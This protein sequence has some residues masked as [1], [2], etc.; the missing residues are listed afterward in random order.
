MDDFVPPAYG[1]PVGPKRDREDLIR[2]FLAGSTSG[3]STDLRAEGTMLITTQGAVAALRLAADVVL[4]RGHGLL[5]EEGADIRA[6]LQAQGFHVVQE[7]PVLAD[8]VALMMCGL[9]GTAWNLWGKAD[10]SAVS[11]LEQ[12]ATGDVAVELSA[13]EA[14]LA[15]D[16]AIVD[17]EAQFGG[18][19]DP[20]PAICS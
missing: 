19:T 5:Q 16:L 14:V 3:H 12:A 15:T 6:P 10:R 7:D 17:F 20:P 4:V 9:R 18:E 2:R 13:T 11:A 8:V 1:L